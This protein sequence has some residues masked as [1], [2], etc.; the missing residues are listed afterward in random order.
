MS[1]LTI[2]ELCREAHSLARSKGWY[3][4]GDRNHAELLALIHSE[5][6][7]VLEEL[8]EGHEP[9]S[10][11]YDGTKPLGVAIEMADIVIR[12]AD[13]AAHLGVDLASAIE[14]KHRYNATRPRKHGKRF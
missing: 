7:E 11:R 1:E 12:V 6:S 10:I 14:I 3:D 5:V 9:N 4:D 2:S 13:M 8:R